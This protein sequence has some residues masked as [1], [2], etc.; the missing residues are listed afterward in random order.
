ML[1]PGAGVLKGR[2]NLREIVFLSLDVSLSARVCTFA[3]GAPWYGARRFHD[4][5]GDDRR[6]IH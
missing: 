1:A 4:W 3:I 5:T 2:L 6:S